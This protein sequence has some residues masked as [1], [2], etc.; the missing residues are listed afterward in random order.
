LSRAVRLMLSAVMVGQ[1]VIAPAPAVAINP[2]VNSVRPADKPA[3]DDAALRAEATEMLT[4]ILAASHIKGYAVLGAERAAALNAHAA[5]NG[6]NKI[7]GTLTVILGDTD[8]LLRA[9]PGVLSGRDSKNCPRAFVS[10][11]LSD[12]AGVR[13]SRLFTGCLDNPDEPIAAYYLGLPR[14]PGGIFVFG[15]VTVGSKETAKSADA[16]LRAAMN[17]VLPPN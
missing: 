10:D 17:R 7:L 3:A 5:W 9:M 15:T 8:I 2:P 13:A 11:V 14:K 4:R 16:S 12:E 1:F 6:P